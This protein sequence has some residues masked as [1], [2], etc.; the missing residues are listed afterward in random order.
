MAK[1][2]QREPTPAELNDEFLG[3]LQ[4]VRDHGRLG[5]DAKALAVSALR[6]LEAG[7]WRPK[8]IAAHYDLWVGNMLLR[9]KSREAPWGFAIIDW[10]GARCA[11]HAFYE[12]V[13][14]AQSVGLSNG[15]LARQIAVHAEL[16]DC[17]PRQ[18][19]HYVA[20]AAGYLALNL[21]EWPEDKFIASTQQWLRPLSSHGWR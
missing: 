12:L 18:A 15:E 3:P 5:P 6:D 11:G 7:D 2:T 21:G 19:E 16:L 8:L 10:L 9:S 14:L 20:A 13:R 1:K 17:R 4:T